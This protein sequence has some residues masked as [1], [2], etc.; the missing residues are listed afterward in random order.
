[1]LKSKIHKWLFCNEKRP[2]RAVF[3]PKRAV[4]VT[5]SSG[6]CHASEAYCHAHGLLTMQRPTTQ[7][8]PSCKHLIPI[9]SE[10]PRQALHEMLTNLTLCFLLQKRAFSISQSYAFH[11]KQE[12]N[13]QTF[14]IANVKDSEYTTRQNKK[15]RS[16][17]S[18]IQA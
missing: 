12:R 8:K 1:M 2:K 16:E 9:S 15:R 13:S 7:D 5:L 10:K 3:S 11:S 18:Q 6:Y 4:I 14:E 17:T